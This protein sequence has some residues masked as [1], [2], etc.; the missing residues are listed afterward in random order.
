MKKAR[1][2]EEQIIG[3]SRKVETTIID[4]ASNV[5][6]RLFSSSRTSMP[7][8]FERQFQKVASPIPC[9]RHSSAALSPVWCSF[10]MPMICYSAILLRFMSVSFAGEQTNFKERTFQGSRSDHFMRSSQV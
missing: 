4:S 1:V 7:P 3:S 8:Y 9:F 10:R 5:F 6:S 2:P